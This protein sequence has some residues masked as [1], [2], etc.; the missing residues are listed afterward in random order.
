MVLAIENDGFKVGTCKY[1]GAPIVWAFNQS[2]GGKIPLD[3][4]APTFSVAKA[5]G[6]S[7]GDAFARRFSHNAAGDSVLVSHFSTCAAK[8][9]AFKLLRDVAKA[10][11]QSGSG[12]YPT[13]EQ[14]GALMRTIHTY[15]RIE[16]P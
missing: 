4:K 2:G 9:R 10:F 14:A 6:A 1:C 11:R 16:G 7:T 5:T 3:A 15:L 8:T 12:V 13:T